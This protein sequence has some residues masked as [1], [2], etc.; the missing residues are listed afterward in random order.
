[1]KRLFTI[2]AVIIICCA[3]TTAQERLR[4][5][6]L[7]QSQQTEPVLPHIEKKDGRGRF[8]LNNKPFLIL[9]AQLWNSS[10]WPYILDKEWP[11]L[12]QLGIN[13]L[14][15]PVYWQ[16]IEET[17]GQFDFK[18]LDSIILGARDH[19]IKLILLWFGSYKNGSSQYAPEWLLHDTKNYPRMI[20][21]AGQ[22][23]L[24]L[25]AVSKNNV[26]ADMNAFTALMKHI[27]EV[28]EAQQTVIMVQVENECGSLGTDRDYSDEANTLF[29]REKESSE[30]FQAACFAEYVEKVAA[31]GKAVYNLPMYAN[32]WMKDMDYRRPGEYPSGGPTVNV[33]DI[34]KAKAP[35]IDLIGVDLYINYAPTFHKMCSDYAGKNNVLFIP[36]TGKG[37]E[38][39]RFQFYAI[40][41]YKTIGLATYGIDPFH[42]DPHDKRDSTKLDEK[43]SDIAANYTL[44]SN[45]FNTI[46]DAQWQHTIV[47]GAQ[48]PDLKEQTLS[49]GDYDILLQYGFPTYRTP[50]KNS[51]RAMVIQLK[52][53]EFIVLGF[54]AKFTFRPKE[55]AGFG[56]CEIISVEE[57]Y[58][59]GDD[60]IRK[61][62][63]N[64]DEVYHSTLLPQGVI[65]KIKLRKTKAAFKGTIKAN[66]EQ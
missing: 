53:D 60:W 38:F 8:I 48:E 63:W 64:G 33:L 24:V 50:P 7:A 59:K 4:S 27:K 42:A 25:S 49:L 2:I 13:T 40:A 35:S 3:N 57:G 62:F 12:E 26:Q 32:V 11:Q 61:R 37:I 65:L 10:A 46:L 21:A 31:A 9:G 28:D 14:E 47:A 56:S 23:L 39:A 16:Q 66:F 17:K 18:N 6:R 5:Y 45:A 58:F 52:E 20:N 54:D 41:Q 34:W 29:A 55:N 30:N 36:E 22:E 19:N 44:F 43:F 51:G 1:M 15:V